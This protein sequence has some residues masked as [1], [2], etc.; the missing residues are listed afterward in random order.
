VLNILGISTTS[1]TK[2]KLDSWAYISIRNKK[3]KQSIA[4]NLNNF[5]EIIIM[6]SINFKVYSI[7]LNFNEKIPNNNT[8]I[9]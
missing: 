9:S 7:F 6:M 5:E 3:A 2:P 8:S 4:L 1:P